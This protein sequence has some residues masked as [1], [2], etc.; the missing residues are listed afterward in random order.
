MSPPQTVLKDTHSVII[1]L[2]F[3]QSLHGNYFPSVK[4]QAYSRFS[5]SSYSVFL[6]IKQMDHKVFI[7]CFSFDN[8][9][10]DLQK[11]CNSTKNSQIPSTQ[12]PQRFYHIWFILLLLSAFLSL[13]LMGQN[14]LKVTLYSSPSTVTKIVSFSL[15]KQEGCK[16][17]FL[18]P[19]KVILGE[20]LSI[21]GKIILWVT[22][23]V[24]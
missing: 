6:I 14:F 15:L 13:N 2:H 1:W 4:Y 10:S 7:N 21:M 12:I 5:L 16:A 22:N 20:L 24:S 3:S 18:L 11:S 17:C 9:I 8:T 19:F 23:N